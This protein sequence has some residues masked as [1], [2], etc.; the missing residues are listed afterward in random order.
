MSQLIFTTKS[1]RVSRSHDTPYPV[2]DIDGLG[3]AQKIL[4]KLHEAKRIE[5][6]V[7]GKQSVY[8][9]IQ[10]EAPL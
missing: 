4:A 1:Q 9:A 8:H 6:R 5:G 10:V 2:G 3:A 7:S